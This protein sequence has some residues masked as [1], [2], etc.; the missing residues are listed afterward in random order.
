MKTAQPF[1]LR[2]SI[3]KNSSVGISRVH[4]EGGSPASRCEKE[5]VYVIDEVSLIL[6]TTRDTA[7]QCC[8]HDNVVLCVTSAIAE[9][10]LTEKEL[11]LE[12][13]IMDCPFL[14]SNG[15]VKG[16]AT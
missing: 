15:K 13:H 1:C 7:Y 4:F 2:D 3:F 11:E 8:I 6:E 5:T 16:S 10:N 9:L 14:Q 12:Q